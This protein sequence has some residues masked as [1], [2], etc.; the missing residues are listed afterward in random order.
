MADRYEGAGGGGESAPT[1]EV[2]D[3][4]DA[5]ALAWGV[6]TLLVGVVVLA[7]VVF[8][9]TAGVGAIW[10][11]VTS[12]DGPNVAA[13]TPASSPFS[14]P[15]SMAPMST[16]ASASPTDPAP[17]ADPAPGSASG[18]S[19]TVDVVIRNVSTP[20]GSDPAFVGPGGVGAATLFSVTAGQSVKVVVKNEDSGPHTFTSPG[21]GLSVFI[22]PQTTKTFTFTPKVAGTFAW[23]CEIPCGPWVMGHAGY[24]E[25]DVEV[26]K[27]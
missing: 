12:Q 20:E 19:A 6:V 17:G 7:A 11:S 1:G 22:G 21:L 23:R 14:Q 3:L 27:S 13:G 10:S 25:G 9:L 15:T 16:M 5:H 26:V 24:M 2:D 4:K 18:A 8:G